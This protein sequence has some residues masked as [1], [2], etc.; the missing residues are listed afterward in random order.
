[1][2]AL[3][4]ALLTLIIAGLTACGGSDA[5][6]ATVVRDRREV[7][8][9]IEDYGTALKAGRTDKI[10]TDLFAPDFVAKFEPI[11]GCERF[12]SEGTPKTED[13]ELSVEDVTIDGMSA[14]AD[15]S[16]TGQAGGVQIPPG[17]TA[18]A[19]LAKD[20]ERWRITGIGG[21]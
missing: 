7:T 11:G 20:G 13:V 1:M 15:F 19:T 9:V 14:T 18:T 2:H 12:L 16:A 17:G 8:Q 3:L 10:C 4:V 5:D 21:L 6:P